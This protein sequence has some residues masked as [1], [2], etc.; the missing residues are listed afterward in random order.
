MV[1]VA[2]HAATFY[3][4]VTPKTVGLAYLLLVILLLGI[5][6]PILGV[7]SS[8]AQGRHHERARQLAA[9]LAAQVDAEIIQMYA[10]ARLFIGFASSAV[11]VHV[12]DYVHDD[13]ATRIAVTT[14]PSTPGALT[15]VA[16]NRLLVKVSQMFKGFLNAV[17]QPGIVNVYAPVGN[18][19]R[20]RDWLTY[21]PEVRAEY[22]FMVN[23]TKN[24]IYGPGVLDLYPQVMTAIRIPI[25]SKL[26]NLSSN[27]NDIDNTTGW[28]VNWRNLWGAVAFAMGLETLAKDL[29]V[30]GQAAPDF[31]V[32]FEARP[33]STIILPPS[34]YY[35]LANSAPA[36][37]FKDTIDDCA[38]SPEHQNLCFRLQPKSGKWDGSNLTKQLVTAALLEIFLPFVIIVAFLTGAR[39]LLGP[40]PSPLRDAPLRTPFY[41]V[42]VDMVGAIKMWAEVPFIMNEVTGIFSQQLEDLAQKHRVFI[43]LRLGNTVIAA[44]EQRSRVMSFA[45]ALNLWALTYD[46]PAHIVV[47]LPNNHASFSFTLHHIV[48]VTVRVDPHVNAF[49]ASGP[50]IQL[51]LF[52]RTAAIPDHVICT[53]QY[54]G[55]EEDVFR[56]F[57]PGIDANAAVP[58][59]IAKTS[60][61][62]SI[63]V[64]RLLGHVREIGMCELSLEEGVMR[65]VRGFLVPSAGTRNRTLDEVIDF[66]PEEVWSEWRTSKQHPGANG[67]SAR[68]N[69][70]CDSFHGSASNRSFSNTRQYI[71]GHMSATASIA[72]SRRV[73]TRA[74]LVNSEASAVLPG[75]AV[76][77][78]DARLIAAAVGNFMATVNWHLS[79][80]SADHELSMNED[81]NPQFQLDRMRELVSIA[82]YFL[83][84]YRTLLSPLPPDG[85][86]VITTQICAANGIPTEGYAVHLAARCARVAQQYL[87]TV[88][89]WNGPNHREE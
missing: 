20:N 79:V 9:N 58:R 28:H 59:S 2:K 71:A 77:Y 53:A 76:T 4:Y 3:E 62:E 39:W 24:S 29:N 47:H 41:A 56:P 52:L 75:S 36:S 69:P 88:E 78:G 27:P 38:A 1:R 48:N 12:P 35:V 10:A 83:V 43:A 81:L 72:S 21:T 17:V 82:T 18:P 19:T 84:A 64:A 89:Q 50:D 22:F 86:K 11:P 5:T 70:L 46:W 68:R 80:A 57:V 23:Y 14:Q 65:H 26:S 87:R 37:N 49:D 33:R 66:L 85:Q 67:S 6:L 61:R 15:E 54:I 42:C 34:L 60:E 55:L 73:I 51:L 16:Y 8:N 13:V 63:E 31:D 40:K 30:T 45:Q 44:S 74:H 32:L 25:W 7:I